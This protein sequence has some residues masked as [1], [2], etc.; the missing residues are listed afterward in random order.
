MEQQK[1]KQVVIDEALETIY[2]GADRTLLIISLIIYAYCLVSAAVYGLFLA[3][4]ISSSVL[5]GLFYANIELNKRRK[6]KN[7]LSGVILILMVANVIA[8]ARG[9][10]EV[11]YFYFVILPAM[12]IYQNRRPIIMASLVAY[13]YN[14][15]IFPIIIEIGFDNDI[16]WLNVVSEFVA[17]YCIEPM[18]A[19]YEKQAHSILWVTGANF[20]AFIF[21]NTL[22]QRTIANIEKDF[23][24][25]EQIRLFEKNK[26][27]ADEIAGGNLNATDEGVQAEDELGISLENMRKNLLEASMR[28]QKERYVNQGIAKINDI[29]RGDNIDQVYDGLIK[30]MVKYNEANQGALFLVE[31]NHDSEKVLELRSIYAY[32]RKKYQSKTIAIGEGLLGQ[33]YLEKELIHLT[34]VPQNY[35]NITSGLGEARPRCIVVVPLISNEEVVGV[36]ELASFKLMEDFQLT[37]I[38]RAAEIIAAS[39]VSIKVNERT[40][41]LLEDSQRMSQSM[42]QT[43]EEMRQNMEEME[44]TREES[45]RKVGQL[46]RVVE[47]LKSRLEDHDIDYQDIEEMQ[48][49]T[50]Y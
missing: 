40:K 28:E 10:V 14:I 42:I 13:L 45:D 22:R 6:L 39:F 50:M 36:I 49:A 16:E 9:I 27:I 38:R 35:I 25:Q 20:I 46:T 47:Q 29:L 4:V 32:S 37:F 26:K 34:E 8:L 17:N 48:K 33:A 30:E 43:E 21:A 11:R 3:G 44:A 12:I 15:A 41:I 31:D 5:L 19:T 23:V 2:Q 18:N 7:D 1:D 24:Q